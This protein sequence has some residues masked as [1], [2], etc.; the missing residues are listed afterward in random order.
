[1]KLII[2]VVI[3]LL[4]AVAFG[5]EEKASTGLLDPVPPKDD[6]GSQR[7]DKPLGKG[8]TGPIVIPL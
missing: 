8:M 6:T 5:A 1:M 2:F 7:D 3:F 4:F